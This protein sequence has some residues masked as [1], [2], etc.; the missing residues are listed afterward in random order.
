LH[1]QF[2]NTLLQHNNEAF[3]PRRK[4]AEKGIKNTLFGHHRGKYKN[5][6]FSETPPGKKAGIKVG[7]KKS[8]L[9]F[10]EPI[11]APSRR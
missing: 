8:L 1:R 6:L 10:Q 11:T 5:N 4:C 2:F 9:S 7:R 3:R